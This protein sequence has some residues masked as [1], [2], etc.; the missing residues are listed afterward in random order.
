LHS[1]KIGGR[2]RFTLLFRHRTFCQKTGRVDLTL[3]VLHQ[4]A[5]LSAD[6]CREGLPGMELFEALLPRGNFCI[7]CRVNRTFTM[8]AAAGG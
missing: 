1:A 8:A 4:A 6:R 2:L 5:A 7:S 3:D